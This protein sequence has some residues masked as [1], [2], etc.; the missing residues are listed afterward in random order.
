MIQEEYWTQRYKQHATG[1]DVGEATLPLRTYIDQLNDKSIKILIPG[2]GNAYEAGYLHQCGFTNTYILDISA[3]PLKAFRQQ[4]P[5]FPDE[6]ILHQD[7]FAHQAHYDLILEQTFFC[8]LSPDLRPQYARKMHSLL[9]NGGQLVGVL[10]D[11]PLYKDH[12]PYGGDRDEYLTYFT[13][14]FHI[15]TFERCTNSIPPRQGRELFIQLVKEDE[16]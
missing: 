12:P 9:V 3:Y 13:P 1:W 16:P 5:T 2:S 4:Y 15:K 14:Y 8:A 7:F 11:D 6:H 10:F